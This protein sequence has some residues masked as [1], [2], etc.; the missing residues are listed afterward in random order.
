MNAWAINGL[1]RTPNCRRKSEATM[2][3]IL[4]LLLAA[5][6]PAMAQQ[7]TYGPCMQAE[8]PHPAYD[9]IRSKTSLVGTAGITFE[10]MTS[11]ARATDEEK[12]AIAR[13]ADAAA[14]CNAHD[15]PFR[16]A[17]PPDAAA[18]IEAS[19]SGFTGLQAALYSGEITYGQFNTTRR[20]RSAVVQRELTAI[21]QREAARADAEDQARRQA[22]LQYLLGQQP[23]N[24]FQPMQP[25]QPPPTVNTNC[26]RFGNQLTCTTR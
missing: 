10:M 7:S 11:N 13:W 16:R 15:A 5:S 18:A 21:Q 3:A 6:F 22:A 14:K 23:R 8:A 2:K 9:A 4:P 1:A 12:I 26:Y 20:E 19:A 24:T 25:Y 17:I